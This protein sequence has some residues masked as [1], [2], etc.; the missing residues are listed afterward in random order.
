MG[1]VRNFEADY[2]K[3]NVDDVVD[4]IMSSTE[5][6]LWYEAGTSVRSRYILS[7]SR[8]ENLF[9]H[10]HD[11]VT[12]MDAIYDS[13]RPKWPFAPTITYGELRRLVMSIHLYSLARI[14]RLGLP[15]FLELRQSPREYS[16]DEGWLSVLYIEMP[17]GTRRYVRG[18]SSVLGA[19]EAYHKVAPIEEFNGQMRT[20]VFKYLTPDV[21]EASVFTSGY[22]LEQLMVIIPEL[23]LGKGWIK[24]EKMPSGSALS[25]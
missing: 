17:D 10:L 5:Q 25:S 8:G 19:W 18:G 4:H 9:T 3:L 7:T 1:V 21:G 22:D 13:V 12:I 24:L 15:R 11:T 20:I 23:K 6:T 16:S 2:L 14:A